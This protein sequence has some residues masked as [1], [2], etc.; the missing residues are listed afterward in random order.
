[1]KPQANGKESRNKRRENSAA[2]SAIPG[3]SSQQRRRF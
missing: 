2:P 3:L 1:M